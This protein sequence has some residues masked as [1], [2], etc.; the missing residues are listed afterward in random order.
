MEH[1]ANLAHE[2]RTKDEILQTLNKQL[3]DMRKEI[4]DLKKNNDRPQQQRNAPSSNG[5]NTNATAR[6]ELAMSR[7]MKMLARPDNGNYCWTHGYILGDDHTSC[8]CCNKKKTGHIDDATRQ[9]LQGGR[10]H[11]KKERGFL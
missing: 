10:T 8:T 3:L 7:F 4:E 2:N 1:I 9:N 5:T 6:R 11:G